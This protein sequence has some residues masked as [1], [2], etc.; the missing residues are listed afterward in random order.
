[1]KMK[2][3]LFLVVGLGNG[4]LERQLSLLVTNL[5]PE[6]QPFVITFSGG[7][8][9]D[10]L[11]QNGVHVDIF[12]RK[13]LGNL[14]VFIQLWRRI[15]T[16]HPD[17]IHSWGMLCSIFA[18]IPAKYYKI[19][20]INGLIRNAT[21]PPNNYWNIIIS[22]FIFH[23]SD[24]IIANTKAGLRVW[25]VENRK[26]RVLPNGFDLNRLNVSTDNTHSFEC[27]SVLMAARMVRE[28]DYICLIK[29]AQILINQDPS[30]HFYLVGDGP[31]YPKLLKLSK[32]MV[33]RGNM[34]II[35]GCNNVIPLVKQAKIGVLMSNRE[36]GCS[37]SIMEY[38]ACGLPVICSD[39]GGNRELVINGVTGYCIPPNDYKV[40]SEKLLILRNDSN[41]SQD[42]GL[43]GKNRIFS[44]YSV[45]NMVNGTI[46]LYNEVLK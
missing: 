8:F 26:G 46:N 16:L 25:E 11:I 12:D 28:K 42:M 23:F 29:A 7:V 2:K 17:I 20:F 37:N 33:I 39:G 15:D 4:G 30:W 5:P 27:N 38:M 44:Y 32:D 35:Q 24:L 22:K 3:I 18:F 34:K 13:E 41:L 21:L 45:E 6:W 9:F 31:D 10:T 19:P 40:L 36:E 1:M 14:Q 43:A